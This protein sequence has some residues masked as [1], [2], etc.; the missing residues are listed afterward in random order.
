MEHLQQIAA[1]FHAPA[2]AAV[3]SRALFALSL[4]AFQRFQIACACA[5]TACITW[6]E[7]RRLA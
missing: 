7:G 6:I 2:F 1:W 5:A 3:D 4:V